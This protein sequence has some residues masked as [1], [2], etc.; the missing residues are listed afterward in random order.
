MYYK[1]YY[2][3]MGQLFKLFKDSKFNTIEE[4]EQKCKSFRN[5]G[6]F[7]KVIVQVTGRY[8]SKIVKIIDKI[9]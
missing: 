1:I 5:N 7:Q 9:K 6:I 8:E 4:A 2:Y 3:A